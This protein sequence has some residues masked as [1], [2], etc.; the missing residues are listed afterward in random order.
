LIEKSNESTSPIDYLKL[1]DDKECPILGPLDEV[2][3]KH[4]K[5]TAANQERIAADIRG[6]GDTIKIGEGQLFQT[7][8]LNSP[9]NI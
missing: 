5:S 7:M 6:T 1:N 2:I 9:Q 3:M 4:S 8:P